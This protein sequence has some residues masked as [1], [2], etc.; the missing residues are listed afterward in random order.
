MNSVT[1][2]AILLMATT[3][4]GLPEVIGAQISPGPLARAHTQLEGA[5]N[6]TRCHGPRRAA[7][8]TACLSCHK[9]VAWLVDRNRGFHA[10]KEARAKDCASCHPDHAGASFALIAWPDGSPERFDHKAAGW[11]LEGGHRDIK[12]AECHVAEYRVSESATLLKRRD[13]T[14]WTGLETTCVSCHRSDDEHRG[15]LVAKCDACHDSRD[16][17]PAPRFSHD[18]TSYA[19]TGKHTDVP[20]NE[21]H[22]S[23]RLPVRV[24]AKGQGIPVYKPVPFRSCAD[25]HEDPHAGRLSPRCGECHTTKGFTT[26]E[27]RTFNHSLTKYPLRGRH[28]RVSCDGCHGQNLARRSP[29][30]DSCAS[31]HSDPHDGKATLAGKPADCAACHRVEGFAP[32]SFTV[33][34]HAASPYPLEGRHAQVAC[35]K[36]HLSSPTSG[37]SQARVTRL[38]MPFSTCVDCHADS[39]GSQLAKRVD[40]G[41]CES[42]HAVA[43]WTPSTYS[44]AQ[45][46]NLRL[47]LDGRHAEIPCRSCHGATRTG[48]PAPAPAASLGSAAFAITLAG[49]ACTDCHVDSHAGRY[50][51]SG[52]LPTDGGCAGCHSAT[53]FRPSLV[54]ATRHDRFAF[55]L[56]GAHR[57]VACVSCHEELRAKP[58]T[59]T[60]LQSARGI[61]R[62]PAAAATR[63]CATCHDNPHGTQFATRKDQSCESCHGVESFVPAPRFDHERQASFSLRGAHAKVACAR[64]HERKQVGGIMMTVYRPLSGACESCHDK[65]RAS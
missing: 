64:C 60:L 33:A 41:A 47:R 59:S 25:C 15:A 30:F 17:K 27:G 38:R 26:V 56:S 21:C 28:V 34:Q 20:C 1:F 9:E 18:S 22:F 49:A 39:H 50:G 16:W 40:R 14:G 19:L 57:A 63:S 65:R 52:P 43:G 11:A 32:S 29:A 24:D 2:R 13:A 51:A 37:A 6:C 61:T 58:A 8:S 31:C 42:C 3:C 35:A 23:K 36:C 48:L 12:C 53:S 54:D 45:H 10:S 46:A 62:F 44:V 55:P 4:F 7:M 5:L